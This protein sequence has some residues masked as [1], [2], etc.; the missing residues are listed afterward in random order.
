MTQRR[1][2][3]L[4]SDLKLKDNSTSKVSCASNQQALPTDLEVPNYT[5]L[6]CTVLLKQYYIF[7]VLNITQFN[8]AN[9]LCVFE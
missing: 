8:L 7:S 3:L 2:L 9:I 5:F 1:H 4:E 6:Y